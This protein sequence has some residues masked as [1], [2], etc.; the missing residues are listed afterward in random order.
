M[1]RGSGF[2]GFCIADNYYIM[3]D[4]GCRQ[5]LHQLDSMLPVVTPLE[6]ATNLES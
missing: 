5:T 2:N 6:S 3:E 1:T 4:A